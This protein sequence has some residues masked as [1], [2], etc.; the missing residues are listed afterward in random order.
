LSRDRNGFPFEYSL[1]FKTSVCTDGK[2]R[3]VELT[4]V[5]NAAGYFE[6]L[7][8]PPGKPLTKM[9]HVP[10]TDEDYAKLDRILKDRRSILRAWTLDFLERPEKTGPDID[11]I[12][13]A[14][15]ITVR[16]SMIQDAAY[17]TWALWHW[18]NGEIVPKLREI[19][20]KHCTPAYLNDLLARADRRYADFA[21]EYVTRHHPSDPRFVEGVCRI[22]EN[23]ERDQIGA[24]LKFLGHAIPDKKKL[25]AR[26]IEASCR[27]RS[28]DCPMILHELAAEADLPATTI[29][30]LT[31]R[32]SELEFFP[33]HLILRMLEERKF[34]SEQTISDVTALLAGDNF[35]VARRAY[36]HLVKQELGGDTQAKVDA[37]LEQNRSRL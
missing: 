8:Y 9:E 13:T 26:L 2:C 28:V 11:A 30:A 36:E 5:W 20:G 32:L 19:T 10:F 29:E 22:L 37:F 1:S 14:T 25:H 35:F 12:T 18:A 27:M 15:P 33:I 21:L 24:S 6:R 7:S 34:A 3:E 23:G 31:G 16:D 4:M 17:T